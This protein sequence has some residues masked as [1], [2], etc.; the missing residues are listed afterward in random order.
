MFT[1]VNP[2]FT[3]KKWGSRGSTLYRHVLVMQ[4]TSSSASCHIK[5]NG[6]TLRGRKFVKFVCTLLRRRCSIRKECSPF[7]VDPLPEG[8]GMQESTVMIVVSKGNLYRF[9]LTLASDFTSHEHFDL[10]KANAWYRI[11][12]MRVKFVF[13]RNSFTSLL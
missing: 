10:I 11:D 1:P 13:D 3:I 8:V 2:S 5:G 9:Y 12:I 4:R 7:R 6:Y